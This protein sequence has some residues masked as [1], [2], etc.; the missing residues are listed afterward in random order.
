MKIIHAALAPHLAGESTT[1]GRRLADH[2]IRA[3]LGEATCRTGI[4]LSGSGSP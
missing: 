2:P 4:H 3:T 1:L